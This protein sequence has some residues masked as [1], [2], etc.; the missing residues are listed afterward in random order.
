MSSQDAGADVQVLSSRGHTALHLAT[1]YGAPKE[2]VKVLLERGIDINQRSKEGLTALC[3]AAVSLLPVLNVRLLIISYEMMGSQFR[4]VG[5]REILC[6]LARLP[7]LLLNQLKRDYD[8]WNARSQESLMIGKFLS[9][10]SND[11]NLRHFIS[12]SQYPFFPLL[13]LTT[14][15]LT[16]PSAATT[17][18]S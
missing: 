15:M 13:S 16:P 3:V 2:Y 1:G 9:D 4:V 17:S 8:N 7:T 18:P 12:S 11:Q 14:L 6:Y 10:I 5:L